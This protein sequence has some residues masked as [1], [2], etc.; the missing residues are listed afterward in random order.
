MLLLPGSILVHF[1]PNVTVQLYVHLY[2]LEPDMLAHFP[3]CS[4][5]YCCATDEENL[6]NYQDRF[7]FYHFFFFILITIM[8]DWKVIL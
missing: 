2:H 1:L 5:Y 7:L 6:L 4:P 8:F 3:H